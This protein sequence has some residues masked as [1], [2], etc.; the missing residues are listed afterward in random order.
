MSGPN[1][2]LNYL[3]CLISETALLGG[4]ILIFFLRGC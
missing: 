3:Y 4:E 1:L 2:H